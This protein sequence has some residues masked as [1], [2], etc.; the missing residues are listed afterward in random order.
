MH[1]KVTQGTF[2][3]STILCATVVLPLA[4]PPQIPIRNASLISPVA[5][6]QAGRP[7]LFI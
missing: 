2:N 4:L 1:N 5:L 7:F 6:Y 3:F